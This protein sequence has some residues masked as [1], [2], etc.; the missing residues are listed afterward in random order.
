MGYISDIFKKFFAGKSTPTETVNP[1]AVAPEI[2]TTGLAVTGTLSATTQP[3]VRPQDV[4]KAEVERV[5]NTAAV[6]TPRAKKILAVK[7]SAASK[8][9][10]I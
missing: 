9:K 2:E 1:V 10:K 3:A 6:K 4:V 7:A 8:S 5:V